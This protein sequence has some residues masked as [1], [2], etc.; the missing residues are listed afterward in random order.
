MRPEATGDS[1]T[2]W[3][4]ELWSRGVGMSWSQRQSGVRHKVS[5]TGGSH[6]PNLPTK[7]LTPHPA[8]MR[9]GGEHCAAV[10]ATYQKKQRFVTLGFGNLALYASNRAH[11]SLVDLQDDISR[12]DSGVCGGTPRFYRCHGHSGVCAEAHPAPLLG[13]NILER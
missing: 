12:L 7:D 9:Q 3:Y 8:S 13:R 6:P 4:R 5:G 11:G 1:R 10:S 2:I